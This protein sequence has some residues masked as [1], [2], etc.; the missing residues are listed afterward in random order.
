[1]QK[2]LT[3]ILLFVGVMFQERVHGS[4][5]TSL[6]RVVMTELRR[7]PHLGQL[8][9]RGLIDAHVERLNQFLST[10]AEASGI[11]EARRRLVGNEFFDRL[12]GLDAYRVLLGL[13]PPS[14]R[15]IR[16]RAELATTSFA[17]E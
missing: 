1:M 3:E 4:K 15:D 11:T 7:F 12:I 6:L 8:A 17:V 14:P 10:R 2:P 13:P 5:T 16:E 9:Y